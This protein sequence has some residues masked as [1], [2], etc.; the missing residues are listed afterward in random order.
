[1]DFETFN[2]NQQK[3]SKDINVPTVGFFKDDEETDLSADH[4]IS[5]RSG[6]IPLDHISDEWDHYDLR[7]GQTKALFLPLANYWCPFLCEKQQ[8]YILVSITKM[9]KYKV[10]DKYVNIDFRKELIRLIQGKPDS[11]LSCFRR[12]HS[13][14]Y[15]IETKKTTNNKGE[16]ENVPM[17]EYEVYKSKIYQSCVCK[18][19]DENG[20]L[21]PK[22]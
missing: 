13:Q 17:Y 19:V 18:F 8:M 9:I 12:L 5:T 4:W 3:G 20:R 1:M 22:F 6:K 2:P 21:F 7:E 11:A 15:E 14:I 16:E 10:R